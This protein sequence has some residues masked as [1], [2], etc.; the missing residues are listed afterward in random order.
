MVVLQGAG[1]KKLAGKE[2]GA[3][4]NPA[5]KTGCQGEEWKRWGRWGSECKPTKSRA[6]MAR[7]WKM[8]YVWQSCNN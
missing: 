4:S 7:L 2:M 5:K 3:N 6:Q 8:G 1:C